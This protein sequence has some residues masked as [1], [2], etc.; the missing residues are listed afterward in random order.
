MIEKISVALVNESG[1]VIPVK[2]TNARI[3][4]KIEIAI[5]ETFS[6]ICRRLNDLTDDEIKIAEKFHLANS[7]N[8][9]L[10]EMKNDNRSTN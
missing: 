10:E 9:Y 3:E 4:M 8:N 2:T 6:Q 1:A 7:L 5:A